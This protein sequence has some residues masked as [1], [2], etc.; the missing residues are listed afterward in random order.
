MVPRHDA[1]GHDRAQDNGVARLAAHPR[2]SQGPAL[3]LRQL[4]VRR[5][6]PIGENAQERSAVR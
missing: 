6:Q 5:R 1:A 2:H 3:R 4:H